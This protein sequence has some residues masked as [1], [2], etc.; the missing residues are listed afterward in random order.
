[1]ACEEIYRPVLEEVDDLLVVEAVLVS[2]QTENEIFLYKTVNF[3]NWDNSYPVVSDAQVYV[4]DENNNRIQCEE[5]APGTYKLVYQLEA[6]GSYYLYIEY[7]REKYQSKVQAV[8][9]LPEIDSMYTD[10]TTKTFVSGVSNSTDKIS[11][12]EGIQVYTDIDYK[13]GLN[14]YRFY[15]RKILQH[16]D[17]FEEITGMS[18]I[19]D[20][21]AEYRW[22]SYYP[23]GIFNIAGP[24]EYSSEKSIIKHELDFFESN[25]NKYIDDSLLFSGWIYILYQYGINED[26]YNFY[27][28]LNSQ[29]DAEGKIFDPVYTQTKGNISCISDSTKVV[30]GNFEISSFSERRFFIDYSK[31]KD[32]VTAFETIPDFYDI[33]E[34]GQQKKIKPEFWVPYLNS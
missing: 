4:V 22:M 24:R 10:F 21:F 34:R 14:H 18:P 8:P 20:V 12:V 13:G 23:T 31:F 15:A 33:P 16:I 11:T 29:L 32:T 26:T 2:N 6:N 5:T 25:Y 19:P 28:D 3:N 27:S 1:M 7:A 9:E 30:L 17:F